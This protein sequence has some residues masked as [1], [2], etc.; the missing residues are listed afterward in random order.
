MLQTLVNLSPI[1]VPVLLGSQSEFSRAFC[2]KY[3]HYCS[4]F[5]FLC[6]TIIAS[7]YLPWPECGQL[8]ANTGRR[9]RQRQTP[10][11]ILVRFPKCRP[12]PRAWVLGDVSDPQGGGWHQPGLHGG[13]RGLQDVCHRSEQ[14]FPNCHKYSL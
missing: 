7:I 9:L 3:C 4:D 1:T 10:S 2:V 5:L 11:F 13:G 12:D 8:E 14:T 6:L